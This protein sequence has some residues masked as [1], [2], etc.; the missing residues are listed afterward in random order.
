MATANQPEQPRPQVSSWE[1]DK[2]VYTS[3]F[4][5]VTNGSPYT[6]KGPPGP[7]H[8]FFRSRYVEMMPFSIGR[9]RMGQ[10]MS[11]VSPDSVP[12][13]ASLDS[14]LLRPV[15]VSQPMS[16]GLAMGGIDS[17]R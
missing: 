3:T 2:H 13:G 11:E 12:L 10:K 6:T 17:P 14:G 15:P 16:D 9:L 1:P 5:G 8:P 7:G 4:K